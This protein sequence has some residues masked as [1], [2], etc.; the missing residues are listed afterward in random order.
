MTC[1][2]CHHKFTESTRRGC[3]LHPESYSG[4]TAQRWLAPGVTEGASEVHYFWS[5][6]GASAPDAP[7]CYLG[8]HVS[9]DDDI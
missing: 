5:C 9:Y 8:D 3:R 7:G 4:E 6:C 1:R 2:E